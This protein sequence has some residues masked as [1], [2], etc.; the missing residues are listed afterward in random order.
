MV[1]PLFVYW[2]LIE[3]LSS[4]KAP[5][6]NLKWTRPNNSTHGVIRARVDKLNG[7]R[8]VDVVAYYAK[9][10]DDKRYGL[11]FKKN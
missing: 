6:P 10:M 3:V 9:T 4:K 2:L 11:N 8:P 1:L 7:P 5:L